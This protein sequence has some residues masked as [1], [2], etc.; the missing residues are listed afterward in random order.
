MAAVHMLS[1]ILEILKHEMRHY[2]CTAN[3]TD[4]LRPASCDVPSD[5]LVIDGS[6][7]SPYHPCRVTLT[8]TILDIGIH[9]ATVART[10]HTML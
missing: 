9:Q 8:Q 7:S 6:Y 4:S 5:N 3:K 2:S 10:S 1:I